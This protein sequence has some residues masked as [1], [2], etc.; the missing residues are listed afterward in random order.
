MLKK[1]KKGHF[2]GFWAILPNLGLFRPPGASPDRVRGGCFY[3]NPSRR[4]PVAPPEAGRESCA[5]VPW[6]GGIPRRG[7]RGSPPGA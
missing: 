4:G 2:S 1:A 6:R 5:S 3:I 7:Y